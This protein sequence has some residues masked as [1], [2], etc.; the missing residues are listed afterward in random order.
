[1]F[2]SWLAT[3][4]ANVMFNV[5]R[6]KGMRPVLDFHDSPEK[7]SWGQ[8][9]RYGTSKNFNERKQK[10]TLHHCTLRS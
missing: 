5:Y 2:R 7:N 1:M 10:N 8:S 4:Y 6:H 3:C 9:A